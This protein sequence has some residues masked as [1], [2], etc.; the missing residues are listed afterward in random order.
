MPHDIAKAKAND[1]I[2]EIPLT[3]GA[4]EVA[5]EPSN[6]LLPDNRPLQDKRAYPSE[7]S[8]TEDG[9]ETLGSEDGSDI[10]E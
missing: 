5:I 7:T 2:I 10:D 4:S 3:H 8:E 6:P 1:A 9:S